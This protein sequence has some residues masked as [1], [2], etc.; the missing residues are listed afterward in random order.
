[1]KI[2]KEKHLEI[3]W[4]EDANGN[5]VSDENSGECIYQV[6]RFPQ[7][8]TTTYLKLINTEEVEKCNHPRKYIV[9]TYGWIDGIVGRE[10]KLCGGTQTKKQW[11]LWPR[12]WGAYG[13]K[14]VFSCNSTWNNDEAILEMVNSGDF[15]LSEAIIVYATSCERC[16][17]VLIHKYTNGEDGYAEYTEE[18][19]ECG[20]S[21][22]F[23]I[24]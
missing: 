6:S 7:S 4:C 12:K 18:W 11:H 17:N 3:L 21:C 15:T 16:M 19:K 22:Q 9:P 23:C 8:L 20:T 2:D 14:E 24:K 1:M 10:C 5:V 13:S